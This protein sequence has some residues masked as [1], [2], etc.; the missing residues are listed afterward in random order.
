ME[1][2][3]GSILHRE[4]WHDQLVEIIQNGDYRSLYFSSCLLQSRMSISS[5][6]QLVLSYTRYMLLPLPAMADPQ[7]IL[8]IGIG[9]GSLL[10][11]CH[12][13]FPQCHIDAVD[14]SSRVIDLARGYFR[15][16]DCAQVRVHCCEGHAYLRDIAENRYY[17]HILVDAFDHNGMSETVY[18]APFF[19]LCAKA[20][21]ENGKLSCN[22]W[23]GDNQR[24]QKIWEAMHKIFP[25]FLHV[26]IPG[27]GNIVVL[28]GPEQ[29]PWHKFDQSRQEWLALEKKFDLDFRAMLI[30][31]RRH[32]QNLLQRLTAQIRQMIMM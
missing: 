12:H 1:H 9:A 27:K 4:N 16:P 28:A 10:R 13:H 29:F 14:S 6:E 18:T 5:P 26:P 15:L 22:I 25:G 2:G 24:L 23:S 19:Q 3:P 31:T 21:N 11:F 30:T 17:D 32:N 20:L 7:R 8:I